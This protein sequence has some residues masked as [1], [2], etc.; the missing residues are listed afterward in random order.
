MPTLCPGL[1]VS[2]R[3]DLEAT[4]S[5]GLGIVHSRQQTLAAC[6]QTIG[7]FEDW[8]PFFTWCDAVHVCCVLQLAD[9]T[10]S[11]LLCSL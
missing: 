5:W 10:L 7:L 2:L 9:G 8:Y 6:T 11:F 4:E 1:S 3:W